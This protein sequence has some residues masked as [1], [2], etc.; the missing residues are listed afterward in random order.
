M[1]KTTELDPIMGGVL[2]S[3][4][5]GFSFMFVKIG[6]DG[7]G[8]AFHL[9]A[10]RFLI[11]FVFIEGLRQL[12]VVKINLKD[13]NIVPLLFL[14]LLQPLIY[15]TFEAIGIAMTSSSQA[16]IMIAFLPIMTIILAKWI[17]N[18]E[19]SQRQMM[20]I[21]LSLVGVL[22]VNVNNFSLGINLQGMLALFIAVLSAALF[23][24]YSRKY[25]RDF[26][27]TEITY[28][29]M[30]SGAIVFNGIELYR[31]I[32]THSLNGYFTPLADINTL[33]AICFL[34]IFASVLVFITLNYVLSKVEASKISVF[35]NFT[36]FIAICA[37]VL[38]MKEPFTMNHAIG[39]MLII[40]GVWGVSSKV[41][42]T[43]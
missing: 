18:E 23:S 37:G 27:P 10:L 40:I 9:L 42:A 28:I 31:R 30:M 6:L 1:I 25:S 29:M 16:G 21:L 38:I 14:S 32:G 8:D 43:N 34:A 13:K 36:T 35:S 4:L 24:V 5:F 7:V 3:S 26:L 41:A 19:T 11:A 12:N 17:L 39:S 33:V 15:F 22:I 20:F 2:Y